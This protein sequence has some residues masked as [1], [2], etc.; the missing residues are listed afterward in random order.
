M[1]SLRSQWRDVIAGG[2]PA[3]YRILLH[4]LLF[5]LSFSV[6]DIL[7][8][9]YLTSLGYDNAFA[10]QMQSVFRLAGVF[11][12]LPIGMI[13]DLI[14]AV[15]MLYIGIL[16]Y[17]IGWGVLLT[18][19]QTTIVTPW[20][21]LLPE[22][23]MNVVYFF[24]G[25]ANM[26]TYTAV[27]P[28]LSTVIEPKQRAAMF[29]INAAAS[30]AMGF[31]GSIVGG[32]LPAVIAPALGVTATSEPAY[33]YSMYAVVVF[34]LLAALPLVG[35]Q[36]KAKGGSPQAASTATPST[37]E[38][39]TVPFL[40]L[41]LLTTPSFFFGTAGGMF[42]PFQNLFFRQEFGMA[43]ASVGFNLA[44]ASLAMGIGSMIGG[45]LSMRFGVRQASAW[46]RM[47]AAPLMLMMLIPWLPVVSFAYDINRLLVGLTFP[48]FSALMM[49]TV[50]LRQRGT[51]TSM[52][53]MSWSLGW[54]AASVTSGMLQSEGFMLVLILSSLS[55]V[56]SGVLIA[57][58][59]YRDNL[60]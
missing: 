1:A 52:S 25:A 33:R 47:L 44:L 13:I 36:T 50:P 58:L 57:V 21:T 41:L 59:P 35:I 22:Q 37:A 3:V 39:P 53:S 56:I 45:P 40:R 31:V 17:A 19:D 23:L 60:E 16:T 24:I 55:Y 49:Q 14:S 18:F 51:S 6:A 27:V 15:R 7:F 12:G 43:D 42:V 30:T 28:L 46:S 9:F 48:L 26:A 2:S 29:G 8:N 20:F 34:G 11:L 54:A 32:S 10:G 5:G 4:G 38:L